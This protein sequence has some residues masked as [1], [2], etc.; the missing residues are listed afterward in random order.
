MAARSD[1]IIHPLIPRG[2]QFHSKDVVS[3]AC[4][5][6]NKLDIL[7][8]KLSCQLETAA[9]PNSIMFANYIY[10]AK[11]LG[12]KLKLNS[13]YSRSSLQSLSSSSNNDT[14]FVSLYRTCTPI[15]YFSLALSFIFVY[16]RAT[17]MRCCSR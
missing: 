6:E 2:K 3:I 11:L 8:Q 16:T 9:H 7:F 15:F 4:W 13:F 5:I 1:R 12:D 17:Q 10:W 14:H